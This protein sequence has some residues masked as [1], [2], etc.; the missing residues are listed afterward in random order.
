MRATMSWVGN[1]GDALY[2]K[3]A[4]K[5]ARKLASANLKAKAKELLKIMSE[6]HHQ[7]PPQY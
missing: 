2:P 5:D 6:N 1:V 3:H 7:N 4:Q